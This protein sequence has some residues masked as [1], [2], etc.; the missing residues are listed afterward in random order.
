[1]KK[2]TNNKALPHAETNLL[3]AFFWSLCTGAFSGFLLMVYGWEDGSYSC[4]L[5]Q[6]MSMG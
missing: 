3:K 4:I 6:N 5:F 2:K 1:V